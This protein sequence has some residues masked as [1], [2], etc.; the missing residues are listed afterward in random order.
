MPFGIA[1]LLRGQ[2]VDPVAPRDGG[3]FL[4]LHVRRVD[5]ALG[6]GFDKVDAVATA[7]QK[8][9][10]I[11]GWQA[12]FLDVAKA[13]ETVLLLVQFGEGVNRSVAVGGL[14]EGAFQPAAAGRV[15]Q[16]RIDALLHGKG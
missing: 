10:V 5:L 2:G 8:I 16:A 14:N 4:P 1:A 11:E 13:G 3:A 6:L 15:R 12:V 7:H 9:R